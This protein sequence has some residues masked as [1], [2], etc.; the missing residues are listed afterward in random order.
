MRKIDQRL[1]YY[2]IGVAIGT[3]LL[4]VLPPPVKINKDKNPLHTEPED[5]NGKESL[6]ERD[7]YQR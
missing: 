6:E 5:Y 4:M 2:F 3:L 1:L 7:T